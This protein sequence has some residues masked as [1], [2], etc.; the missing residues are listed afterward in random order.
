LWATDKDVDIISTSFALDSSSEE[1]DY[2]V[3]QAATKGIVFI[4]SKAAA[5]L[6]KE[7]PNLGDFL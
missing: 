5:R 3:F 1:L 6:V 7:N 4:Y 2:A